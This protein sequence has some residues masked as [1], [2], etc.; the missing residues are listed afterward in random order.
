MASE[1]SGSFSEFSS[2]LMSPKPEFWFSS[3]SEGGA[4]EGSSSTD[5][6]GLG[7]A[8]GSG[9]ESSLVWLAGCWA[10]RPCDWRSWFS[11]SRAL[12]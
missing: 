5:W 4:S 6:L 10:S 11:S 7:V 1:S 8:R 12:V 2:S 9:A 3:S